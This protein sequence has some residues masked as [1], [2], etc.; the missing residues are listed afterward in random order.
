MVT[1][2]QG[3]AQEQ[4]PLPDLRAIPRAAG[5]ADR[6]ARP[7]GGHRPGRPHRLAI[8]TTATPTS[9]A[10]SRRAFDTPYP[11]GGV[12]QAM[13]GVLMGVCID[14][15]RFD[16][17]RRTFGT[18]CRRSR[19]PTPAS[20]R[21]SSHATGR[22]LPLRPV[23]LLVA[24]VGRRIAAVLQISRIRQAMATEVLERLAHDASVPGLDLDRAGRR[25]RARVVRRGDGQASIRRCSPTSRCRIGS[26]RRAA[27]SDRN[28][29][30]IGLDAAG[31][32]VVDRRR[33]RAVRD[34]SSTSATAC[35]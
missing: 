18:S 11:I 10:R 1:G 15:F 20:G 25:R 4:F 3:S 30:R 2:R 8:A 24:D 9:S 35:R 28:I 34:R 17:D 12:T 16:I 14:R 22:P 7:V 6:H 19:S 23:A 13:T 5:P 29:R 33:S 27:A 26:M 21:C 32:L 31:G